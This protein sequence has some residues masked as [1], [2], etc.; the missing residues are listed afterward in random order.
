MELRPYQRK[1]VELLYA[2]FRS[3]KGN[4]VLEAPTG[5]GKS[6]IQAEFI[7]SAIEQYPQTRVI[8]LT[9]VRELIEQN[10]RALLR[11][12]PQG[13]IGIHSAALGA[14]DTHHQV[15]FAGIQSAARRV[16]DLGYFDLVFIDECHL[17]PHKNDGQYRDT[18]AR[19]RLFNPKL[20]VIGFTAT[21][22]R[23]GGGL[24]TE[25][26]DRI[27]TDLIAAKTAGMSISDLLD[28]GYLAP[29]TTAPVATRFST[30]GV[31]TSKGDYVVSQLE[32]AVT[33]DG[34]T[35]RACEE[36]IRFGADRKGWLL[37]AASVAHGEQIEAYLRERGVRIRLITGQT[38]E[39]VR[40]QIIDQYK[41]GELRAL[42][43]VGVLT[44]GFDAPHTDL[45]AFLRPTKSPALYCLDSETEIL[46]SH[47]WKG[48]NEVQVGDCALARDMQAGKG[49][50]SRVTGFVRRQMS[51]DEN[52]IEY[53]APRA[54]FRVTDRHRVIYASP[55]FT[56]KGEGSKWSKWKIGTAAEM[57]SLKDSVR[58][59][60]AV[61]IDQPG[62][63]L[64]DDELHLIGMILTDGS[65][66]THQVSITQSERHPEVIERLEAALAG[67]KIA[68]TKK[69]RRY[70]KDAAFRS[71][72]RTWTYTISAGDPRCGR[73]GKGVRYLYPW[74]DKDIS[75]A[76]MSL[77]RSQFQTLLNG[78]WDGDGY[79]NKCAKDY[80]PRSKRI[81][82]ARAMAADRL[83]ALGAMH[84]YTVHLRWEHVNRK[85]P[86]AILSFKDQDWRNCGG[87]GSRPQIMKL[88]GTSEEVWC[89]ETEH[90][91]IVTR[92]R[93]R[94]TVMGNCQMAGRGMR[95]APGK[96]DCLV[97]DFANNI[98]EHGPV[99]DVKPPKRRGKRSGE[100]APMR[101]CD[102][103]GVLMPAS[104]RQCPGCGKIFQIGGVK[105]EA[106]ASDL[107]ILSRDSGPE[108]FE[109][110]RYRV[111]IHKKEG[112]P[113]SLRVDWYAGLR[114][115]VTEWVCLFHSGPPQDRAAR[116]WFAHVGGD[117]PGSID[118]A[119]RRAEGSVRLPASISVSRVTE[120][121][122]IVH[123]RFPEDQA[124]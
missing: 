17:V 94:V 100:A 13:D 99:D 36:V 105:L 69:Q 22:Y 65:V 51:C 63:P 75:P 38:P 10:A 111:S 21:P 11:A 6:V 109:P 26:E 76:L 19:L 101:E 124:A 53:Q 108:V 98:A 92:R 47:G 18:L 40:G 30:E 107:A 28:A 86:I 72:Y 58:M 68:Y 80:T 29:L 33:A 115:A 89:V 41:R 123:R 9:H 70:A 82:T 62:V 60:T 121:P 49:V 56:K 7:R 39:G 27:F 96:T 84:G 44:T 71:R 61:Y 119:L 48:I 23:L 67:A 45:L 52:W 91:T 79:K 103:C 88:P 78:I 35:E 90:G 3:N 25:G 59:P 8:A 77:S 122:Q 120:F 32:R 16:N 81:C 12:W 102:Q 43:N 110:T 15:I 46:T 20:K 117:Y 95:I 14:R 50:W 66:S 106:T 97:L 4:P 54:N 93:G 85:N 112:K 1:A 113:D 114:R 57:Q 37:F 74:L 42:V 24:L 5:A 55:L 2:Y 64:T 83:Q 73:P 116:W 34:A 118:E 31:G 104:M 87:V